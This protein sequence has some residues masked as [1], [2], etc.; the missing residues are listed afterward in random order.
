MPDPEPLPSKPPRTISSALDVLLKITG[1]VGILGAASSAYH[2][3]FVQPVGGL[4]V[5]FSQPA[6]ATPA[7]ARSALSVREYEVYN[8]GPGAFTNIDLRITL[9]NQ[10]VSADKPPADLNVC[11]VESAR[12]VYSSLLNDQQT[13]CTIFP[14]VGSDS[15][16]DSGQHFGVRFVSADE[17]W[18]PAENPKL[19]LGGG[20]QIDLNGSFPALT[21][22]FYIEG[23]LW[24]LSGVLILIAIMAAIYRWRILPAMQRKT[25]A[26]QQKRIDAAWASGR[27]NGMEESNKI[28]SDIRPAD[29]TQVLAHITDVLLRHRL[30]PPESSADT[31]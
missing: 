21:T 13:L 9:P 6:R 27:A 24:I 20:R 15:S 16:L 11:P 7:P 23:M 2:R 18:K 10:F 12:V 1:A 29:S 22:P 3:A 30:P 28:V 5:E 31:D 26:E 19:T 25:A 14:Q 8:P 4:T 17:H